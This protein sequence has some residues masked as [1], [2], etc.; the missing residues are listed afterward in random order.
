MAL[1]N[2][3][4]EI[5]LSSEMQNTLVPPI[6]H[7]SARLK[8]YGQSIPKDDVGG[9]LMDLAAE[10]REVLAYVA[11]V[12]GHGLR[13]GVLMAMIKTAVRYG[14]LLRQPVAR[15][16]DD[17][18]RVLPGLKE[19]HMYATLAALRFDGSNHV[20]YVSA[21]HIPLLHYRQR[22]ADVVR[23]SM[24]QFPLGLF[25]D[26]G[27]VSQR[28][29]YEARDMFVL[30]TD[31]VVEL[32]EEQDADL[33]FE[34]LA[35]VLCEFAERPLPEIVEAIHAEVRRHGPQTDDE[36]VLLVRTVGENDAPSAGTPDLLEA[37]WR[38]L[39]EDLAG[40]LAGN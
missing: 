6:D 9:D 1:P 35:H 20:E 29:G 16:L 2:S 24:S 14:L 26:A 19:R 36:T 37:R 7:R 17:I 38:A 28:I 11:D 3:I 10:G 30:I 4:A 18:N 33:G 12:S 32:G 13:S 31:G 22:R 21:G 8:A 23:Y 27:Y 5:A 39:L 34:R 25:G 15:L 40:E